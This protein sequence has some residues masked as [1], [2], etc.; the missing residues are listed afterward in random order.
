M[1]DV[2]YP[3]GLLAAC[4]VDMIDR[5]IADTFEDGS[6]SAR[7]LWPDKYFKRRFTLQH[8]PLTTLE[9]RAV[10]SF[11][12]AR[13]GRYDSFWFRDNVNRGGQAKVR[14]ANGFPIS[15]EPSGAYP[16]KLVFEEVAPTRVL[17]DLDELYTA[18]T[19]DFP[20]LWLDADRQVYNPGAAAP[21]GAIYSSTAIYDNP[22]HQS[23]D[24]VQSAIDNPFTTYSMISGYDSSQYTWFAG[25]TAVSQ[26]DYVNVSGAKKPFT[27]FAAV[28]SAS[29]AAR[30][31]IFSIN[32]S[33]GERL[34]IEIDAS[35]NFVPLLDGSATWTN[36][37]AA[38]PS[39]TWCSVA[40]K[41]A[42]NSN[43]ASL[44]LNGA[45]V[46]TDSNTRTAFDYKGTLYRDLAASF[47]VWSG[48]LGQL[49]QWNAALSDAD[50]TR[51]HNLFAHK[52]GY[53]EV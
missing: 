16:L 35:N 19:A 23:Q 38:N 50:I 4:D 25:G 26:R 37:K 27:F 29:T 22:I 14:L 1:S 18:A 11:L 49:I 12:S 40:V 53:A 2:A 44:Y 42:S 36:A 30:K 41:W 51:V 10:R 39:D 52:Y 6:T 5:T 7:Q 15:R 46:G 20:V 3:M 8:A 34:G 21:S 48:R 33:G 43:N 32:G 17:P 45:L 31:A 28:R 13:S 9:F 24:M 47:A